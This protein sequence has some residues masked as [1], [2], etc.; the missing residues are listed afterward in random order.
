MSF[1]TVII[2]G[3]LSALTCGITL[4][5]AGQRVAVVAGGQNTLPLFGGSMELLGAD[6]A[7]NAVE[8]PLEAIA[9]LDNHHPY[10]KIGAERVAKLAGKAKDL[11]DDASI[12]T[13]GEATRN[14]YRIT[15][16][17]MT[18]PAW[19]TLERMA[20]TDRPDRLPWT[21]VVLINLSGFIDYPVDF[22]AHG[23]RQLGCEVAVADVTLDALRKA[24][25]SAT[26]MRATTLA[27]VLANS[28]A[29]KQLAQAINAAVPGDAQMVL[30][31][32]VAGIEN[33]DVCDNLMAQVQKPLRFLATMPPAVPGVRLNSAL[34]H[35]F[36]MLGGHYFLGDAVCSATLERNRVTGVRAAKQPASWVANHFVMATG[37][38]MSHG[39]E[40][41]QNR[42][43]E[44]LLG[45][46]VNAPAGCDL[47]GRDGMMG[48]QPYMSAGV[49]ADNTFHPLKDGNP[50]HNV[51]AIGQLLAGHNPMVMGDGTGVAML[52]ALAV[53]EDILS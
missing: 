8:H 27:K 29:L 20:T 4:A 11:L 16:L 26:Q 43:F 25:R 30:M 10:R 9:A 22:V 41:D 44:P 35:Y 2:G 31:P 18:K 17:G 19:L 36:Q 1:D 14:H 15:P 24:W 38:F 53:A 23:L 21:Q 33:D 32:A 37:S 39:L 40:A 42:I 51:Y 7:G 5:R 3:G 46:D 50:L 45:L 47:W 12:I 34:K 48:N 52:T 6:A 49:C 13:L 28:Q